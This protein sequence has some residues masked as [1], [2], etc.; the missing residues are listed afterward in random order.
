MMN[1]ILENGGL[2][3]DYLFLIAKEP[4]R[5]NYSEYKAWQTAGL[6]T[7]IADETASQAKAGGYR[8]VFPSSL[9]LLQ[10]E[11]GV[12]LL[13]D[14]IRIT[15]AA[16]EDCYYAAARIRLENGDV[17]R[18]EK[19]YDRDKVVRCDALP[20]VVAVEDA[21]RQCG[22][23]RFD[24]T[25][26]APAPEHVSCREMHMDVVEDMTAA[27]ES[28]G[29]IIPIRKK[30]A[31]LRL[32]VPFGAATASCC[33]LYQAEKPVKA[34]LFTVGSG[35]TG[36]QYILHYDE[37]SRTVTEVDAFTEYLCYTIPMLTLNEPPTFAGGARCTEA[38]PLG[39]DNDPEL[40]IYSIP[41]TMQFTGL[42]KDG[43][44][45]IPYYA[46]VNYQN[47]SEDGRLL[48]CVVDD[49]L[50]VRVT[51]TLQFSRNPGVGPMKISKNYPTEKII[52]FVAYELP[53]LTM[54]PY[55]NF[56]ADE[57]FGKELEGRP[58][59]K[60]YQ[61]ARIINSYQ[62]PERVQEFREREALGSRVD[63]WMNGGKIPFRKRSSR[64]Q[65]H[66]N[67]SV[68]L[69]IGT[70]NAWDRYI[71]MVY[72][73]SDELAVPQE[74]DTSLDGKELGCIIM[75]LPKPVKVSAR[76]TASFGVDIGARTTMIA[77]QSSAAIT[78]VYP[79]CGSQKLHETIIPNMFPDILAE[80]SDIAYIPHFS[81]RPGVPGGA[82][83]GKFLST[84]MVYDGMSDQNM[85]LAPYTDAFVP[86]VEGC[87]LYALM[88]NGA[89][90]TAG[91]QSAAMPKQ[92]APQ[93]KKTIQTRDHLVLLRSILFHSILNSYQAGCGDLLIRFTAPSVDTAMRAG[94]LWQEAA[95]YLDEL[96]IPQ[97]K[98]HI[99]AGEY[100]ALTSDVLLEWIKN[101]RASAV[102]GLP[103]Y[104]VIT[105]GGDRS[106]DISVCKYERGELRKVP[107]GTFSVQYAGQQIVVE[108][109]LAFYRHLVAKNHGFHN[110]NVIGQFR[111]LWKT[112]ANDQNAEA[113]LEKMLSWFRDCMER[114]PGGGE[115]AKELVLLLIG[116]FGIDYDALLDPNART[117]D[118]YIVKDYLYL[119][120]M[121]QCKFLFLFYSIGGLLRRTASLKQEIETCINI[122]LFGGAAQALL[123]AEPL[124]KGDLRTLAEHY[125]QL[126]MGLFIDAM[127]ALPD[128]VNGSRY[129][130]HLQPVSDNEKREAAGGLVRMEHGIA[131]IHVAGGQMPEPHEAGDQTLPATADAL[132][133]EIRTILHE[134]CVRLDVGDVR[135]D[136]FLHF[137]DKESNRITLDQILADPDVRERLAERLVTMW[138]EVQSENPSVEDAALLHD[139][140]L[141][142]MVGEAIETYLTK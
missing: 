44:A 111:K 5:E 46:A 61:L 114:E 33:L 124:C 64:M 86:D 70:V 20:F 119:V 66:S 9:E 69:Q 62:A 79:Y 106:Y 55:V 132:V 29:G 73:G 67:E 81:G 17:Q 2:F 133:D 65:A 105:D 123:M 135:L 58:L 35:E 50:D 8:A 38:R 23:V 47:V 48:P 39:M 126:P 76:M 91:Y 101:D 40:R 97:A 7:D 87:F 84:V 136:Y 137:Q 107:G 99:Q 22:L 122:Y 129:R 41:V 120:R 14:S 108:S 127:M 30:T 6:L 71:H 42:M 90:D 112:D 131:D 142:K 56:V 13:T 54:F 125:D 43:G 93:L 98:A 80:I 3:S 82:G 110:G 130:I 52:E 51:I 100:A 89:A 18:C 116:Q 74:I 140:Y 104:S 21:G 113:L 32:T 68:E 121:I 103:K 60:H 57:S 11:D 95:A 16:N 31:L 94:K 10:G 34:G 1:D 115:R 138:R 26:S 63:F 96:V 118:D 25:G 141:T 72:D 36:V 24:N 75:D 109:I 53:T 117:L 27:L 45:S 92:A 102:G 59:W 19:K 128:N 28:G 37:A 88:E 15:Y 49:L 78:T 134:H 12:Q 83:C 4:S 85:L 139:L 77:M